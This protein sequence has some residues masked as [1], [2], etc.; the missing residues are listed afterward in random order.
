MAIAS[1]VNAVICDVL[2]LD[3]F[4]AAKT[5]ELLM[6]REIYADSYLQKDAAP[7]AMAA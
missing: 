1:G 4:N 3:L 7:K 6:N 2:D 5:A